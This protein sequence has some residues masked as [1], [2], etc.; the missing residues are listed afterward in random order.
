MGEPEQAQR[1]I[2]SQDPARS[3]RRQPRESGARDRPSTRS[4]LRSLYFCLAAAW[5]F[6]TGLG[7]VLAILALTGQ[8]PALLGSRGFGIV[9]GA[10]LLALAGGLVAAAAYRSAS[11]RLR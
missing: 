7:G 4:R 11:R 10:G 2:Q 6:F 3:A 5:G 1:T 8:R 9:I